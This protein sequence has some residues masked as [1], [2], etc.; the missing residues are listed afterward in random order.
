MN[1]LI[2]WLPQ[3]IPDSARD[4]ALVCVVHGDYRLDNLIF[5]TSEAR[6][7]AVLDWEL[8]TVGHALADFSYHC[9]AWHIR[10]GSFRGIGGLDHAALGIPL[11][12]DYVRR[13]CERSGRG[14]PDRLQADWNFYLAYNLFRL[15]A[16]CQGIAKRIETGTAS[17]SRAV[18]Y[19]RQALPLAEL[20]WQFAVKA[21]RVG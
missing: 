9:M 5:H 17:S 10:P 11:E 13:Y 20:G 4:D 16:I 6:V 8:S 12:A 19:A 14:N 7:L 2:E 3:H 21:T 1:R 18:E 15:A